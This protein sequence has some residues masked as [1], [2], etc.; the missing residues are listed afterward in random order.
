MSSTGCAML[1]KRLIGVITV[2][3]GLA[4]QS[5]GYQRYLPLGEPWVLA[6]NLDRWGVDEILILSIDRSGQSEGP[7][8]Q[9]LSSL[10]KAKLTT[11]LIYGGGIFNKNDARQVIHAGADRISLD[12]VLHDSP[13]AVREIADT[14]G[15]QALIGALPL[16]I[17]EHGTQW[18]DYR[19]KESK[20][21][22]DEL[23]QLFSD[24]IISEVLLIDWENEGR[25]NSFDE[26]I[27]ENI[28]FKV[29]QIVFG[30]ISEYTQV[31]KLLSYKNV[32]AVSIG[33]FLTYK[34]HAAQKIKQSLSKQHLRTA[35]FQSN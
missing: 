10:A 28:P 33:N 34:E 12:A 2:K 22:S 24:G 26:G 4:V 1:K 29:P 30:G 13:Q 9:L 7:D 5:I 21:F 20:G 6:E 14:L 8:Y 25:L 27:I 3:N 19:K 16:N 35:V 18:Y 15:V 23:I 31:D 17:T 32:A 11:P